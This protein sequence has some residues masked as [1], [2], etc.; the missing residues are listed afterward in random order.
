M[1]CF[2]HS[3]QSKIS[4]IRYIW[5]CTAQ[6][7]RILAQNVEPSSDTRI[8]LSD[9]GSTDKGVCFKID[10][11][12]LK[13]RTTRWQHQDSRPQKCPLCSRQFVAASRLKSHLRAAHT[14]VLIFKWLTLSLVEVIP[15]CLTIIK[16]LKRRRSS[17][18]R[19]SVSLSWRCFRW[20]SQITSYLSLLTKLFVSRGRKKHLRAP[21]SINVFSLPLDW[22]TSWGVTWF[23]NIPDK[24]KAHF[25][26]TQ[27]EI[28]H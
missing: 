22:R 19:S 2:T 20:Q 12:I 23:R 28:K 25:K 7:R 9:T 16:Y 11:R 3:Y 14:K 4:V 26:F 27:V 8:L 1:I 13:Q 6:R 5:K 21:H 10:L 15:Y 17:L 24:L 18:S